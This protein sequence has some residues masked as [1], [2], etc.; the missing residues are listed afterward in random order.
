MLSISFENDILKKLG[1]EHMRTEPKTDKRM[2][3][4]INPCAGHK[5]G[6]RAL[7][8]I[9]RV[10]VQNG[11]EC[12]IHKTK[13]RGDATACVQTRLTKRLKKKSKR[14]DAV[15]AIG[16]DGTLNEVIAGLRNSGV[17]I[18]IGYIPAGST[19]DLANSLGL[20]SFPLQ[21]ARDIAGGTPHTL[22]IGEF[23]GRPFT[24]VA[25]CGIFTK[26]SYSAPQEV[27]NIFGHLAYIFEGIK[28]LGSVHPIHM[29][30]ETPDGE[31]EGDYIYAALCNSTSFGGV[32]KL[33]PSKV[34]LNDGLLEMLFIHMPKDFLELNR[35]AAA[36]TTR[37]YNE[38]LLEFHS[39]EKATIY[40]DPDEPW[41]LDGEYQQGA[42][43]I[44]IKNIRSAYQLIRKSKINDRLRR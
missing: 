44:V 28:D 39:V 3:I 31:Y 40:T 1:G 14:I 38:P 18:P 34:D 21:A 22:D 12:S 25:S 11:Y 8:R 19:N 41:T 15:T 20:S 29:K 10:F 26:A 5:Q 4:V 23:N 27:K 35:I 16:G 30:V 36:L 33:D 43:T 42:E 9:K 37:N 6:M 32:L 2:L 13:K 7:M 17:N 24:Y